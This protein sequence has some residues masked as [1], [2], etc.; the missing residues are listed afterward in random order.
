MDRSFLPVFNPYLAQIFFIGS[1]LNFCDPTLLF[2][3]HKFFS[4]RMFSFSFWSINISFSLIKFTILNTSSLFSKFSF[5]GAYFILKSYY[6]RQYVTSPCSSSVL[7]CV[8]MFSD[9]LLSEY[10]VNY[11]P[12]SQ[13]CQYL[14]ASFIAKH[15]ILLF[16]FFKRYLIFLRSIQLVYFS[17]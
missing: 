7:D 14:I 2:N 17:L 16:T 3:V 4:F 13:Y 10:T 1:M 9:G 8:F 11:F 15:S 5:P 12:I 6:D